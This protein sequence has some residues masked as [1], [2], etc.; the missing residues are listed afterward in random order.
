L[1]AESQVEFSMQ[2]ANSSFECTSLEFESV[3]A[4]FLVHWQ[5]RW[6]PNVRLATNP[7][8]PWFPATFGWLGSGTSTRVT[9]STSLLT[10]D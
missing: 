5:P 10:R 6:P 8:S 9:R 2:D 3:L 1:S 7:D 4:G